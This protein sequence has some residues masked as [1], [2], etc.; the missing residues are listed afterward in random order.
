[1]TRTN[2]GGGGA[3]A[4]NGFDVDITVQWQPPGDAAVHNFRTTATVRL[5]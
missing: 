2:R 5:N 4:S 3:P 1:V